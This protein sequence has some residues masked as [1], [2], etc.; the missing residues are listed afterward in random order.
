MTEYQVADAPKGSTCVERYLP[1]GGGGYRDVTCGAPA[2][3]LAYRTNYSG[4]PLIDAG[5]VALCGR[6]LAMYRR[7]IE[8]AEKRRDEAEQR[9]RHEAFISRS[10]AEV[11]NLAQFLTAQLGV[12]LYRDGLSVAMS[13]DTARALYKAQAVLRVPDG[14]FGT[15]E[16]SFDQEEA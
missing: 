10:R 6:H 4:Y 9:K 1:D 13:A 2:K 11:D 16:F 3:A 14:D 5:M 7:R 15:K 8:A 12:P